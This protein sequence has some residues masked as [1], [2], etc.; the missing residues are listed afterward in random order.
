M[1]LEGG[2]GIL[3]CKRPTAPGGAGGSRGDSPPPTE[4]RRRRPR[5]PG[6]YGSRGGR[7]RYQGL[8][9][10]IAHQNGLRGRSSEWG[11]AVTGLVKRNGE[12]L[13]AMDAGLAQFEGVLSRAMQAFGL[14]AV[15]VL[16]PVC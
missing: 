16:V 13:V 9:G 12:E 15:N 11:D 2:N 5:S 6:A 7:L 8:R 3:A 4:P 1:W 10:R 14:P